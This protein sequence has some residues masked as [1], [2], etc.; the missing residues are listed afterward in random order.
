MDD[1][2]ITTPAQL[3]D[4]LAVQR[5]N[6]IAKLRRRA[7]FRATWVL[8]FLAVG[9]A[10]NLWVYAIERHYSSLANILVYVLLALSSYAGIRKSRLQASI[11]LE[12]EL[13]AQQLSPP[14]SHRQVAL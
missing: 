8:L 5:E 10:F 3:D 2:Q 14:D 12:K 1:S 11:D 7:S 6:R 4:A 9:V 13:A